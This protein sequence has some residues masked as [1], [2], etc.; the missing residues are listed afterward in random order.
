M[1]IIFSLDPLSWNVY[2][3]VFECIHTFENVSV[4][5]SWIL[6]KQMRSARTWDLVIE[7]KWW[8]T[9]FSLVIICLNRST[10]A[11]S[12]RVNERFTWLR[13]VVT[14]TFCNQLHMWSCVEW[15]RRLYIR[16]CTTNVA[17]WKAGFGC[18]ESR[19]Y[20]SMACPKR[21]RS[22]ENY[23]TYIYYIWLPY[24]RLGKF[25]WGV[26]SLNRLFS[27]NEWCHNTRQHE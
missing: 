21:R 19:C 25:R 10:S 12:Y 5:G 16:V 18:L 22:R 24:W 15:W 7:M 23:Y 17:G 4:M 9:W 3:F 26:S 20:L 1:P 8:R 14:K 11:C 6:C 13:A 27:G 2:Y